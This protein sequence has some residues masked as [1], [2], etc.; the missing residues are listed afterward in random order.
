MNVS[1]RHAKTDSLSTMAWARTEVF[2]FVVYYK[3]GVTLKD[4]EQVKV[5]TRE[6]IDEALSV[7]GSYYLPYQ[8]YATPQQFGKAYPNTQLFFKTKQK[9]DPNYKFRNSLFDAYYKN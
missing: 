7:Q 3:Q 6:L 2:A 9:Y 5:W 1:I 8:I 4:R